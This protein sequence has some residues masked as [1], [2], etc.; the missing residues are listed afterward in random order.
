MGN[1]EKFKQILEAATIDWT[2]D[3]KVSK[4]EL[5]I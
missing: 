1:I 3:K 2:F 4:R 5:K